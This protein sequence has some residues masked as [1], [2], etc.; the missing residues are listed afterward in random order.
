MNCPNTDSVRRFYR[1]DRRD[2]VL[3]KGYLRI[4]CF[5]LSEGKKSALAKRK[6]FRVCQD[7]SLNAE[8]SGETYRRQGGVIRKGVA[9]MLMIKSV[10]ENYAESTER[11]G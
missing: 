6:G 5:G 1:K 2:D 7:R 10:K 4:G 9:I 11:T 8:R 3:I